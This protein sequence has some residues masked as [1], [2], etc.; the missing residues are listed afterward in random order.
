MSYCR[1]CHTEFTR[2]KGT[3]T[4]Y[5][6]DPCRDLAQAARNAARP[7]TND[8]PA[9]R[10]CKSPR[11]NNAFAIRSP[12]DPRLYCC[13]DCKYL[14]RYALKGHA[15]TDPDKVKASQDERR[16]RLE[17]VMRKHGII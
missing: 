17:G 3:T 6:S 15:S 9:M 1:Q 4:R 13:E 11:C 12:H 7:V 5:C 8:E 10:L 2:P 14:N 16:R